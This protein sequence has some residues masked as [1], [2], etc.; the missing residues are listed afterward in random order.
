MIHQVQCK[1]VVISCCYKQPW[2]FIINLPDVFL[3][4]RVVWIR[5]RSSFLRG[6]Y[7]ALLSRLLL[8][9]AMCWH[10]S[11]WWTSFCERLKPALHL[12]AAWTTSRLGMR[13]WDIMRL[14]LVEPVRWERE[15]ECVC[16]CKR[17]YVCVC[18]CLCQCCVCVSVVCICVCV[19]VYTLHSLFVKSSFHHL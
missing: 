2:W 4:C 10:R 13:L 14:W 15:I 8:S 17:E 18:V 3:C 12:K 7:S 16:V 6:A 19:H 5:Y 1:T 9:G 11:A